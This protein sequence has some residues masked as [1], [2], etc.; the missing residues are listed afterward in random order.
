MAAERLQK[1]LARAGYGSRRACESI[2]EAGRVTVNGQRAHLGQSADP[3]RD[4]IRVDGEQ[5]KLSR[6]FTYIIL[7]KPRNVISDEDVGGR[8][9]AA[10]ELIQVEGHL[11]AVGRLDV[12][13]EGLML[14]TDDGDL[15]HRLTHP[16]FEHP[17]TYR[18]WV[19][20][21]PSEKT[22]ETWRRGVMLDDYR[23]APAQVAIR[24]KSREGAELE[25]TLIE[26]RKR[27]IRRVAALL[28]H[29]VRDL[30]RVKLGPLELGGLPVGAWRRLTREEVAA[31]RDIRTK[32]ARRRRPPAPSHPSTAGNR[33]PP[34]QRARRLN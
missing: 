2:I 26:G 6:S 17:K 8:Y 4:E 11:Y 23:T 28:G 31:L 19:Q 13:S 5:L 33:R 10:R 7:N 34:R 16:S 27:M 24:R 25:L 32:P 9:P 18:V 12:E 3:K 22:L 21:I 29:P 20:G 30:V 15:A 1:L 14:F